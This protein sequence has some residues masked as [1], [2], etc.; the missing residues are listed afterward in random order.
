MTA[1]ADD[2]L[3][4]RLAATALRDAV[5]GD[6]RRAMDLVQII[7]Y[8]LGGDGILLAMLHWADRYADHVTDGNPDAGAPAA[9][10]VIDVAT[11]EVR[12]L[13]ESDVAERHKWAARFVHARCA[14]DTRRCK[15]LIE[16]MPDAAQERGDYFA[17][18]LRGVA[19]TIRGLPRGYGWDG[20][21]PRGSTESD[22]GL[23][24]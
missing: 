24:P 16:Q 7:S 17:A 5:A 12:L 19:S 6:L 3:A 9:M 10:K 22:T 11:G 14:M 23:A 21:R 8:K 1:P 20:R 13:E 18:L 4:L 2:D 15:E